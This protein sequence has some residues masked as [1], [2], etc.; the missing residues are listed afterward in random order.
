MGGVGNFL[1]TLVAG[2]ALGVAESMGTLLIG[3]H[4]GSMVPYGLFV[5]ILLFR[6]QGILGAR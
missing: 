3:G 6:P 4:L 1:G 2:Y 5:L